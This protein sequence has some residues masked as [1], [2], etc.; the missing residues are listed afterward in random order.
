GTATERAVVVADGRRLIGYAASV[1]VGPLTL[2]WREIRRLG[3]D[4]FHVI[5]GVVWADAE[6]G[7]EQARN[8]SPLARGVVLDMYEGGIHHVVAVIVVF[9]AVDRVIRQIDLRE[10]AAVGL[11]RV[12]SR[13]ADVLGLADEQ[14]VDDL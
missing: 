10:A 12:R 7:V 2:H 5:D 4:E 1:I 3:I 9:V 14:R 6:A 13:V 11:F 8:R